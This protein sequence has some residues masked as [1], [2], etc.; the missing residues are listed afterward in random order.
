M[1]QVAAKMNNFST[2]EKLSMIV[3]EKVLMSHDFLYPINLG[4]GDHDEWC[5]SPT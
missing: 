4:H 2:I 1:P 3:S 5:G